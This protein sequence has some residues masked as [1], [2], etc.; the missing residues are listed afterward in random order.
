M[1][2][3]EFDQQTLWLWDL[4]WLFLGGLKAEN[5]NQHTIPIGI[6][7]I[8]KLRI[9]TRNFGCHK[10]LSPEIMEHWSFSRFFPDFCSLSSPIWSTALAGLLRRAAREAGDLA[11][12]GGVSQQCEQLCEGPD[13][14]EILEGLPCFTH[15]FVVMRGKRRVPG[16]SIFSIYMYLCRYISMCAYIYIYYMYIYI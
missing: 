15:G 13:D 11:L 4:V 14:G 3:L 1:K 7:R 16:G 6:Y 2:Q 12:C 9:Q 8:Q 5:F 10:S